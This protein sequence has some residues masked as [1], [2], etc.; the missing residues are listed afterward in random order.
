MKLYY[1]PGACSL[2][3]HIVAREAGVAVDLVKVD[4]KAHKTEHGDDYYAINPRGYVPAVTLDDGSLLTEAG[5][6]VQMLAPRYPP[7]CRAERE[8]ERAASHRSP[9]STPSSC[10][11]L[12]K[13]PRSR[14]RRSRSLRPSL[15]RRRP[16]RPL[17]R[18]ALARL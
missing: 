8:R 18:P 11:L 9:S 5:T 6:L 14:L 1:S 10:R 3:P 13:C 15:P 4:L 16:G 7:A 12:R 17:R 2:A